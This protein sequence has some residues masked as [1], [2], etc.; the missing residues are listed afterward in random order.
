MQTMNACEHKSATTSNLLLVTNGVLGVDGRSAKPAEAHVEDDW[1]LGL[2]RQ[3]VRGVTFHYHV[4]HR[5]LLLVS[6]QAKQ[7]RRTVT[8]H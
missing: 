2:D 8:A 6:Q 7:H 1:L 3:L 5:H 4:H